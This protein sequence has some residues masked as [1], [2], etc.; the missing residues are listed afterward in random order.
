M[1]NVFIPQ[2]APMNI[3]RLTLAAATFTVGFAAA[4]AAMPVGHLNTV[5]VGTTAQAEQVRLV[6][7]RYGRCYQT[8]RHHHYGY[9]PR[10]DYGYRYNSGPSVTFGFGGHGHRNG[11]GDG[12]YGNR[13]N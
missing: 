12:Y 11:Y 10:R 13:W 8:R 2:R 7:N 6:C 1:L 5:D 9:A 4:T 3:I